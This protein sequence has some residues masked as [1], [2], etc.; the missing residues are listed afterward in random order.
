[1]INRTAVAL[2]ITLSVP[3]LVTLEAQEPAAPAPE[4]AA[5]DQAAALVA[6]RAS[7]KGREEE[8]SSAV[9]KNVQILGEVPAGRLLR[10]ME[11]GWAGS[12]GVKCT[13][14]HLPGKWESDDVPGKDIA[15]DMAKMTRKI[16]SELLASI[17]G[18]KSNPEKPV[19]NCTTCH[20][21]Q[22]KPA[23]SMGK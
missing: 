19:V 6:I 23:T 8:P 2:L 18:L 10:I 14:C 9:F 7:I 15:R 13:H 22:V 3:A 16:N 17:E 21:G 4:A 20:R 12:L 5:F 1:M 11:Y